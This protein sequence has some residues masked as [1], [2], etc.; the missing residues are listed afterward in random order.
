MDKHKCSTCGEIGT[1]E[2]AP[3]WDVE[4]YLYYRCN[5]CG[6]MKSQKI[7]V[8]SEWYERELS[9]FISFLIRDRRE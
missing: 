6:C 7:N 8:M 2:F 3:E 9:E 4:G 5:C 1:M